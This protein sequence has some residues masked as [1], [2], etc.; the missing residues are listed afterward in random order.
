MLLA[1]IVGN[2]T[3]TRKADRLSGVKYLLARPYTQPDTVPNTGLM[4]AADVLGA[5]PGENV[6][7]ATGRAARI[8]LGAGDD[9]PIDAAVIAIVDGTEVDKK[10]V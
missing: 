3:A 10:A 1:R 6:I 9:V 5:G 7:I 8:A 4:I 2:V